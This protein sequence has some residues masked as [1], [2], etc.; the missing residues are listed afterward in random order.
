ML[1][2]P[3][4]PTHTEM[5][6]QQLD[7]RFK[8]LKDK[9]GIK[10]IDVLTSNDAYISEYTTMITR[11]FWLGELSFMFAIFSVLIMNTLANKK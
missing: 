9:Q 1:N 2:I 4:Q 8:A 11:F 10:E 5:Y 3:Q 7:L 6:F